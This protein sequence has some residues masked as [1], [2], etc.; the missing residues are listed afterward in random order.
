MSIHLLDESFNIKRNYSFLSRI[1][2]AFLIIPILLGLI[3]LELNMVIVFITFTSS[4]YLLSKYIRYLFP[5]WIKQKHIKGKIIVKPNSILINQETYLNIGISEFILFQDMF[6]GDS[7]GPRDLTRNGNGLIFIKL[8][9]GKTLNFKI[10]IPD[11]EQHKILQNTLQEWSEN[12]VLF[13][14]FHSKDI[15]H[16][17]NETRTERRIFN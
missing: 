1:I 15:D 11:E 2:V 6:K 9:N 3:L 5:D 12:G 7:F 17:L 16:I 10:N 4:W 14:K 8:K 13:K